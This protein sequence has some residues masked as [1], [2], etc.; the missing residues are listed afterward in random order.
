MKNITAFPDSSGFLY[1]VLLGSKH[2]KHSAVF[3]CFYF[4]LFHSNAYTDVFGKGRISDLK[5][6]KQEVQNRAQKTKVF[7]SIPTISISDMIWCDRLSMLWCGVH[8]LRVDFY[9]FF[10]HNVLRK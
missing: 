6:A 5:K 1:I 8:F 10:S 2:L 4:V 3:V 7:T 9:V